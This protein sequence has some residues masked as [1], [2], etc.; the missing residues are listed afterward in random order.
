MEKEII[1]I[2][3]AYFF[4]SVFSGN[5]EDFSLKLKQK[6]KIV[7]TLMLPIPSNAPNEI[8]RLSLDS[9]KYKIN[10][11]KNRL[12]IFAKDVESIINLIKNI[13]DEVLNELK[14]EIVRIGFV[15]NYFI[16][17]KID[18]IKKILNEKFQT[19]DLK[20]INIRITKTNI[21]KNYSCNDIENVS[22]GTFIK[23]EN[24]KEIREEGLIILRD[25]NTTQNQKTF[26]DIERN[27]IV[28]AFNDESEKFNLI[29]N[30][31]EK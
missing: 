24:E 12:D 8:P 22:N 1:Q 2:Q 7:N 31:C 23:N 18:E 21:I 6:L 15:K 9:E 19:L 20:E 10:V 28:G 4:K 3:L 27:E 14:V 25:I 5:F 29:E 26:N 30:I 11:V 13:N 16:S 17:G